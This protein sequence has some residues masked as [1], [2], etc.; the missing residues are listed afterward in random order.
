MAGPEDTLAIP[1]AELT[2]HPTAPAWEGGPSTVSEVGPE[3]FGGRFR[4]L[5]LVGTGGMGAVY[6][7]RDETL[8]E[9]VALKLIRP[10]RGRDPAALQRFKQ[11]VKLARRVT[12][13]SVVRTFDLG[14]DGGTWFLTMEY[15]EGQSL[16]RKLAEGGSLGVREAAVIVQAVCGALQAAHDAGV[17]HRDLKP[18][19]VLLAS[20]GRVLLTDFGIARACAADGASQTGLG[21][22]GTPA[23]MAPEQV[24]GR[25][26]ITGAA[27][28]YALGA[29][30]YEMLCGERAWSGDNPLTVSMA[31]L[32]HPPPDPRIRRP[33][34]SDEVAAIIL[35]CLEREPSRRF[36][37]ARDASAALDAA[38]SGTGS[39]TA[40]PPPSFSAPLPAPH[41]TTLAVLPFRATG[42]PGD[43]LLAQGLAEEVTDALSMAPGLRVRPMVRE[44]PSQEDPRDVGRRLGV[45]VV[46]DGSVRRAGERM[47]ILARLI[48]VRDGFQLWAQRFEGEECELLRIADEV[49]H[50]VAEALT[51]E[52]KGQKRG[53]VPA[54]AVELYLRAREAMRGGWH[55]D[56]RGAIALLEEAHGLAPEDATILAWL[57]IARSR[58]AFW[59]VGASVESTMMAA[60]NE[61]QRAIAL[62]PNLAEA[63]LALASMHNDLWEVQDAAQ[64]LRALLR[65]S[66][67]VARAHHLLGAMLL[68]AGRLPEAI[69]HLRTARTLDPSANGVVWE[70]CRAH[71]LTGDWEEARRGV[72]PEPE[73]DDDR[74]L[75]FATRCRIALW[76]QDRSADLREPTL[77]KVPSSPYGPWNAALVMRDVL[78]QGRITP[79]ARQLLETVPLRLSPRFHGVLC[80][81]RAEIRLGLREDDAGLRLVEEAVTSG[82]VDITW[83]DRCPLLA[84]IRARPEFPVLRTQVARRAET[85]LRALDAG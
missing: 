2:K 84:P 1:H 26:P 54:G 36:A 53:G 69:I 15:V 34:L 20:D 16:S 32:L 21:L 38:L 49:S 33:Q 64:L 57:S 40:T 14:E 76:A 5:G 81:I 23:Y 77:A 4:I 45:D 27:D 67:G 22:V 51:A 39:V 24:D 42:G 65:A 56:L 61:A 46:V 6:R 83:M 71:A 62:A 72:G 18:D 9:V 60:R 52:V 17:V 85:V 30:L 63:K 44:E 48:S 41:G 79:S 47:R 37:Q 80:Q 43:G 25:S 75:W 10:D 73:L 82:L 50:A 8:D 31:R 55:S 74:T 66:P 59:A 70:L 35:R 13:P 19:N 29:M 78:Q 3:P 68:E 12:H 58:Q 28:L 11:E 7:A